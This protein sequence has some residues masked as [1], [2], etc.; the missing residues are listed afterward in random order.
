ME[1]RNPKIDA[2]FSYESPM[3]NRDDLQVSKNAESR[4]MI[5]TFTGDH[6]DLPRAFRR[7]MS[8]ADLD[9]YEE[10]D[11]LVLRDNHVSKLTQKIGELEVVAGDN[12]QQFELD[13]DEVNENQIHCPLCGHIIW[14]YGDS[15]DYVSCDN[16]RVYFDFYIQGEQTVVEFGP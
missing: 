9:R 13:L 10:G 14:E 15:Q 1:K 5:T 7:N 2:E 4:L 12:R 8:I 11:R 3:T 6:E 16:C